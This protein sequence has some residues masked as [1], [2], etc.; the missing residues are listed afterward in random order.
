[1]ILGTYKHVLGEEENVGEI[2]KIISS[3]FKHQYDF[4]VYIVAQNIWN[5]IYRAQSQRPEISISADQIVAA[6]SV[7]ESTMNQAKEYGGTSARYLRDMVDKALKTVKYLK[8][9]KKI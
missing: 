2:A 9:K 5:G 4:E 8:E 1:M 3:H 7:Y 6:V